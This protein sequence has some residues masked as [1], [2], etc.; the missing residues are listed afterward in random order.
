MGGRSAGLA[1]ADATAG[2]GAIFHTTDGGRTWVLQHETLH[3][4][5]DVSAVSPDTA[6]VIGKSDAAFRTRDGGATWQPIDS[7][8]GMT[9]L[10]RVFTVDGNNVWV[11]GD[12]SAL[13]HTTNGLAPADQVQWI[14]SSPPISGLYLMTITFVDSQ[15]GWVINALVEGPEPVGYVFRTDDGGGAWAEQTVPPNSGFWNL[16]MVKNTH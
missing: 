3:Q 12:H 2:E 15:T 8:T 5:I 16:V 14:Q 4:L 10:N 11:A 13:L 7:G 1:G 6:W 9:D